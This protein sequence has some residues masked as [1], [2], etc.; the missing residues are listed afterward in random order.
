VKLPL[1]KKLKKSSKWE[2]ERA[3]CGLQAKEW[4]GKGLFQNTRGWRADQGS[5]KRKIAAAELREKR[6]KK[7]RRKDD[8][9]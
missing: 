6:N 5:S 3:K 7:R 1:G 4:D 9:I 2:E 8:F